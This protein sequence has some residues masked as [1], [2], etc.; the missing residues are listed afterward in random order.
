MSPRVGGSLHPLQAFFELHDHH[1]D[2]DDRIVHQES[3][4]DHERAQR[5]SIEDAPGD[6]HDDED[7]GKRQWHSG[8]HYDAHAPAQTDQAYDHD[9]G[10]S[11]EELEH[12][13]A[14][15]LLNVHRLV[16]DL[17]EPHTGRQGAR[18]LLLF[19]VK[20]SA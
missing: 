14:H 12:E 15:G 9:D 8:R 1:F 18:D 7:C 13:F 3:E 10:E 16:D 11:D 20:R 19:S 5:N 17:R 2:R 4:R 6:E